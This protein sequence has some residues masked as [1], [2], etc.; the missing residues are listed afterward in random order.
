MSVDE[1]FF[2]PDSPLEGTGFEPSVPLAKMR[3]FFDGTA[4]PQRR[5]GQSRNGVGILGGPMVRIRLP[6]AKSHLRT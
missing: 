3:G 1:E 5:K 6:P 2:A 4:M